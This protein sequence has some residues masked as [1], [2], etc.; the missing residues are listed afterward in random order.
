VI[1]SE[2]MHPWDSSFGDILPVLLK[3]RIDAKGT[4]I[5]FLPRPAE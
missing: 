5:Y 3:E 4:G 1:R 2:A